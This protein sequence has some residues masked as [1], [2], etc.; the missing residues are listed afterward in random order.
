[1]KLLRKTHLFSILIL[2][3]G[4]LLWSP[5]WADDNSQAARDKRVKD[6]KQPL[7]SIVYGAKKPKAIVYVFTDMNCDFCRKLHHE[8]PKLAE[9]GIQVRVLAMPRQGID[10]SGYKEWVSIWCSKD[11][12][13]SLDRAMEGEEISAKI[14][15]NPIKQHYMLG[16]KWGVIGTP[17]VLFLDGTLKAGYFSADK[18]AREAIKRNIAQA[19]EEDK[20]G[21][22]KASEK[23]LDS[24]KSLDKAADKEK[25]AGKTKANEKENEAI[26]D[27]SK[28][29]IKDKDKDS[30]K[31][32]DHSVMT[33]KSR[34]ISDKKAEIKAKAQD[35]S[36]AAQRNEKNAEKKAEKNADMNAK[37]ISNAKGTS[38]AVDK[39]NAVDAKSAQIKASSDKENKKTD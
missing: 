37:D 4:Q 15:K 22:D 17:S 39:P 18:L 23:T 29:K 24:E 19:K 16:R 8:F 11:P 3:I 36:K 28:E 34:A 25:A 38:N 20:L 10:S 32:K 7:E 30:V 35:K 2:I 12:N 1:M 27:K 13:D 6:L 14:C 26:K 9:Q 31:V 33:G 21:D 5:A